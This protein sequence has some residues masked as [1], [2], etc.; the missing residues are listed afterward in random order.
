MIWSFLLFWVK[1]L[2]KKNILFLVYWYINHM[3]KKG[4]SP[5]FFTTIFIME[6]ATMCRLMAEAHFRYE[7]VFLFLF[8]QP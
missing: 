3:Q 8:F 1:Y 6:N 5:A 7:L 4:P 2:P